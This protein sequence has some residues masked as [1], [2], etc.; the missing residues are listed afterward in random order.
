MHEWTIKRG[1]VVLGSESSPW[2]GVNNSTE[3]QIPATTA[4]EATEEDHLRWMD[5]MADSG[6]PP[7]AR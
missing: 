2:T 6:A 1:E 3:L 4:P 5:E 7:S